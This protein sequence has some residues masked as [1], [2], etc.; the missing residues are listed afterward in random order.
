MYM[1]YGDSQRR[2]ISMIASLHESPR[3]VTRR[4][5]NIRVL[6]HRLESSSRLP[7][8]AT[9]TPLEIYQQTSVMRGCF[10]QC[11][12]DLRFETICKTPDP[13]RKTPIVAKSYLPPQYVCGTYRGRG[14][15]NSRRQIRPGLPVDDWRDVHIGSRRGTMMW[16]EVSI[17]N[18]PSE[19]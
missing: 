6:C 9:C 11:P 13:T 18:M 4:L 7:A 16:T 17:D 14:G 2:F 5:D 15:D 10:Y 8:P 3:A 12:T 19:G 1:I